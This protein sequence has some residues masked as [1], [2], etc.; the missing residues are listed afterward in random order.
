MPFGAVP[1]NMV[2]AL[3]GGEIVR[4]ANGLVRRSGASD[5]SSALKFWVLCAFAI[6]E[7]SLVSETFLH[8]SSARLLVTSF[9]AIEER[10]PR[11][12]EPTQDGHTG[13]DR[14]DWVTKQ[15]GGPD[16]TPEGR[17]IRRDVVGG[18]DESL[19]HD[20]GDSDEDTA[21]EGRGQQKSHHG[22]SLAETPPLS[23]IS[24]ERHH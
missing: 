11:E 2:G 3:F 6:S 10:S 17:Q 4:M 22:R 23:A 20:M 12:N 5:G 7:S 1:A 16:G 18:G 13:Q 21:R 24:A 9:A 15:N 8:P 19:V 14:G